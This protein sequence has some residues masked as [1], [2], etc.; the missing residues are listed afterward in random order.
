MSRAN[1]NQM[2]DEELVVLVNDGDNEALEFLMK[3]YSSLVRKKACRF[4]LIGADMEDL[5]QEGMIG[6]FKAALC[7]R[8]DRNAAFRSFAE[9]CINR[10]LVTA[11]KTATR[12][13]HAPLN[14]YVSLSRPVY[15][16]DEDY[17]FLDVFCKASPSNPEEI[18]INQEHCNSLGH[19]IK[20]VL[21]GFEFKVF[22]YYMQGKT[23]QEISVLLDKHPKSIDNALQRIKRKVGRVLSD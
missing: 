4:F 8:P 9:L 16:D 3:K 13:K 14:S 5:I 18:M 7:Y 11:I 23:Y 10:Q 12:L 22:S 19:K 17:T 6:L 1:F 2:S 15:D 21:S 20:R